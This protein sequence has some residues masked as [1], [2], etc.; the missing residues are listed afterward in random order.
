M[1]GGS[2]TEGNRSTHVS[3]SISG[4]SQAK[5]WSQTKREVGFYSSK[6]PISRLIE[7]QQQ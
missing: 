3:N 1:Q 7:L 2:E 6:L 5:S 4:Y